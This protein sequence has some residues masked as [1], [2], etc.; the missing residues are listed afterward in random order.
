[1]NCDSAQ[2]Q[3]LGLEVPSEP[4]ADVEAHLADCVGCRDWLHR[5][6]QFEKQVPLLPVPPTLAKTALLERLASAT[7]QPRRL[8]FFPVAHRRAWPV[9][10][11]LAAAS[12]LLAVAWAIRPGSTS[13]QAAKAVH[14]P[15][16]LVHTLVQRDLKLAKARTA[17]ERVT[18]LADLADD[19]HRESRALSR[20]AAPTELR[21]LAQ[22]LQEVLREC[23]LTHVAALTADERRTVYE[24]R[25][26]QLDQVGKDAERWTQEKIAA[27]PRPDGAEGET[28]R[29]FQRNHVLIQTLVKEGL[30]LAAE[31]DPLKRAD[32]CNGVTTCLTAEID[33]AANDH[34]DGRVA[35]LGRHL[36][37]WLEDGVA[38]NLTI[39]RGKIKAGSVLERDLFDVSDRSSQSTR[40][41][42]ARLRLAADDT[43]REE[44]RQALLAVAR[45]RA[46][47]DQAV[48]KGI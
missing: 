14:T 34:E 28:V 43:D 5:L 38:F 24:P 15:D 18:T 23:T 11:G 33:L 31:A 35:E 47:V 26:G 42:E 39:A 32:V 19:L 2:R 44:L 37:V 8:F 41:V 29:R 4:P 9:V 36:G 45:G 3:L 21:S 1:M 40:P 27:S 10:V 17:P 12:L 20:L 22:L 7:P 48:R 30:A 13:P 6:A 25:A 16:P 46:V